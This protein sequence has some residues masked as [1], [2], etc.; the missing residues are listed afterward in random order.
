MAL[1][2]I[3]VDGADIPFFRATGTE[4]CYDVEREPNPDDPE[5]PWV[6]YKV[7]DRVGETPTLIGAFTD[8]DLATQACESHENKHAD[9]RRREGESYNQEDP[10]GR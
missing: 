2:F 5:K 6:A 7:K 3:P 4:F 10:L 8:K 1:D 9:I